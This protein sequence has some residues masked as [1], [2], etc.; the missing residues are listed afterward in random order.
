MLAY[1]R[2]LQ[3]RL[4]GCVLKLIRSG[5]R[6]AAE[7]MCGISLGLAAAAGD[8][9]TRAFWQI[10]AAYFQALSL[11]L[12]PADTGSKRLVSGILL[13]YRALAAGAAAI[14]EGLPREL[15]FRLAQIDPALL[16]KAPVLAALAR[17]YGLDAAQAAEHDDQVKVIG[18]LRIRIDI[19][20]AYLNETDEWSR[21]LF[22]ELSEWALE[23]H[24]RMAEGTPGLAHSLAS[25]SA[26]VGLVALAELADALEQAL[27]HVQARAP[28]MPQ[29]VDLF[30]QASEDIRRLLHQFAA[31]FLKQPEAR[32]LAALRELGQLEFAAAEK[33]A[34]V[35]L[36]RGLA[37]QFT[38]QAAPLLLQLGGALRQWRARPDNVG[39]R[40]E[41]LR[42]LQTLES[43]A[44]RA[45]AVRVCEMSRGLA[46][47]I[48]R[49]GTQYVQTGQLEPLSDLMAELKAELDRIQ[50][51]SS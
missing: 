44:G 2:P 1:D 33:G 34:G 16:E 18:A 11:G 14:S 31:G 40:N 22:V 7:T 8:L 28:V 5:D 17:A 30:L 6:A 43:G 19:F 3:N 29:H 23:P 12:C 25:S 47:G 32:L 26:N 13:Q 37:R 51:F 10:C 9:K 46:T 27:R 49:S 21:R 20:N 38:E 4:D 41:A 35:A 36:D 39:A 50:A 24:R 42:V 48:E 45:G 15:L